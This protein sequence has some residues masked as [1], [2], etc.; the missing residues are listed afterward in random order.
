MQKNSQ[1]MKTTVTQ[2]PE[3]CE[4]Q[5]GRLYNFELLQQKCISI[6]FP[7]IDSQKMLGY[8]TSQ[9]QAVYCSQ[10]YG[11][12]MRFCCQIAIQTLFLSLKTF[13][14]H[15]HTLVIFKVNSLHHQIHSLHCWFHRCKIHFQ[16]VPGY[17]MSSQVHKQ[18]FVGSNM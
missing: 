5:T 2:V 6:K 18:T 7:F 15:I 13:Y 3:S 10:L 9:G 4:Q 11:I 17:D 12:Q 16:S 1:A 14:V 8:A